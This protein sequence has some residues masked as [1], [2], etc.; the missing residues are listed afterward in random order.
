MIGAQ[1]RTAA[2]QAAVFLFAY[3][4]IL[5]FGRQQAEFVIE[6]FVFVGHFEWFDWGLL[7]LIGGSDCLGLIAVKSGL[8]RVACLAAKI[9]PENKAIKQDALFEIFQR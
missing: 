4:Y 8:R 2:S 3:I 9:W 5:V 7:G 1:R 6:L